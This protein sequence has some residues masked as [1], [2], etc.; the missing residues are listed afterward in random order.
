MT[1]GVR[2]PRARR[3]G[4]GRQGIGPRVDEASYLRLIRGEARGPLAHAARLG[5]S[6]AASGYG[7]AVAIRDAG[8]DRGWLKVHRAPVPVVAVGNL[9][10]GGTGKTPMVE[11][12]ARWYR[13]RGAGSPS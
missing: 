1:G 8:Y 2:N 13:A 5:L 3:I 7:L 9:T 6:A 11:W 12:V 4:A 10:L